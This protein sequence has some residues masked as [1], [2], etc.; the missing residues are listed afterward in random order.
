MGDNVILALFSFMQPRML[1]RL[2]LRGGK[3]FIDVDIYEGRLA[4]AQTW[5]WHVQPHL[6]GTERLDA[7]WDWPWLFSK[8]VLIEAARGRRVS[9]QCVNVPNS[10]GV[11]VPLGLMLLSEG[12][13]ALDGTSQ[14]SV[15]LWYLSSAPGAALAKM[16]VRYAKPNLV[17]H[18]LIDTAIQRSYE[19]GYD[20]RVGLHA[21]P[22]GGDD[23]Y[24][25]YRDDVRM[26][27]LGGNTR[28]T[29]ARRLKGGNDG[30]YFWCDPKLSQSLSNSLDY[31][32]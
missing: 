20:G 10:E 8:S 1:H 13:P 22:R 25:R 11:S 28:L 9:L 19:L 27:S 2:P 32:R 6:R 17:L 29:L 30:R 14:E 26:S 31:L 23:L 21:A 24:C 3:L 18:A 16:G 7:E 15:F 4:D 12:Y 5:D